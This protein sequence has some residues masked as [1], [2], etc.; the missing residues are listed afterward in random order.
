MIQFL[1]KQL[2]F[3]EKTKIR[4]HKG[5][6]IYRFGDWNLFTV[7]ENVDTQIVLGKQHDMLNTD[8]VGS[9]IPLLLSRKS[10]KKTDMTLDI[11][12]IML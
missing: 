5:I 4:H 2:S 8:I 6:N 3:D 9:D 7:F 1:H 12:M 10:M 11:K